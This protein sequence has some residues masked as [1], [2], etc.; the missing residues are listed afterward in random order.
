MDGNQVWNGVDPFWSENLMPG[1]VGCQDQIY[2]MPLDLEPVSTTSS[3]ID[4]IIIVFNVGG[5]L[6]S[7]ICEKAIAKFVH[8]SS[9]QNIFEKPE[10]PRKPKKWYCRNAP[11]GGDLPSALDQTAH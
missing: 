11:V 3:T 8:S 6:F 7:N 4:Y 10:G 2:L 9:N 5:N 1:L